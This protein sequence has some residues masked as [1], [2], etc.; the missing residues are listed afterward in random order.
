[1]PKL[2]RTYPIAIL[3]A[4]LLLSTGMSGCAEKIG[5]ANDETVVPQDI[6]QTETQSGE[7]DTVVRPEGWSEESHGN[8]AEPNYDVVF[9][10]DR[11]NQITITIAPEDWDAMQ[12]DMV[13][14]FGEAGSGGDGRGLPDGVEH[15][16]GRGCDTRDHAIEA[17]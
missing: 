14:L 10:D 3:L 13:D 12:A 6:A 15:V 9:P 7:T 8:V 17:W 5:T 2:G 16:L 11:V 1:M 4:V